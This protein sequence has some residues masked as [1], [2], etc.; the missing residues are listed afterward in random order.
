[1]ST[2]TIDNDV[3]NKFYTEEEIKVKFIDFLIKELPE[4]NLI[5]QEIDEKDLPKQTLE[6]VRNYK[7]INFVEYKPL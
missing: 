6:K 3:I 1:M 2:I 7:N 4:W 5:L